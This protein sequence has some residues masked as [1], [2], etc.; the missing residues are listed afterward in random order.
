MPVRLRKPWLFV[1]RWFFGPPMRIALPICRLRQSWTVTAAPSRYG[2][3]ATCGRALR[4]CRTLRGPVGRG[5]FPPSARVDV[6]SIASSEPSDYGCTATRW[7]LDDIA[8]TILNQAHAEA[9]SRST[10]FRIL[11]GADLKPHRSVYWLNSHDPDFQAKA[12][13]V[14][15]LYVNAPRLQEQGRLLICTDEKTGMQILERK[16]PTKLAEPG[17]PE[18][19]EQEYIR[20]GTLALIGSFVVPTGEVVWDVGPTRTSVDF[21][22]HLQKVAEHFPDMRG[23][24]WV[25]DNLNTH[26]SLEVCEVVASL[27]DVA[28]DPQK[29]K[30]GEQRREFL[31]D[32]SH[33]HVFHFTPKHGSWLNQVELWFSILSRRFLQRGDFR[34]PEVFTDQLRRFLDDYNACHAHPFRWTY[35]G[36]PLVRA[37]PF[38]ATRRQQK[39]GK[40][41]FSPRPQCFERLLYPPRPYHRI[42][43]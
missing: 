16:Y 10:I 1:F 12:R 11:D 30:R 8:A 7:S 15:G 20:H 26:W 39:H 37:T 21:A 4:G 28:F 27:S 34:S 2:E 41:W 19:R 38:S 3:P 13:E 23:F 32:S 5:G 35:T 14:C 29:L 22:A 9:M 42:A 18:R 43:V 31:T 17:K 33:K 24:D 40:A 6:V 36:Q 25:L